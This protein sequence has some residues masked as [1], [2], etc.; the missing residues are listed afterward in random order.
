MTLAPW[1]SPLAHALHRNRSLVYARYLQ[2]AT[3]GSEQRP[4]NRTIVFRGFL[5]E[6]NTLKFVTDQRSEKVNQIA[7]NSWGEACWYF[8][9]TREQFRLGGELKVVGE[10]HPDATLTKARRLIWQDLSDKG[11][12]QFY[13]PDPG[14]PQAET[15]AFDPPENLA[16]TPLTNFCL[17]LLEPERVDHLELRGDPQSRSLYQ[18]DRDRAHNWSVLEVNP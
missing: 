16:E 2:L 11:R 12:L 4:A 7:V 17:L 15:A 8:P 6:T 10:N 14:Q 3:L 1:R 9:K 18:W 13:W 5:E